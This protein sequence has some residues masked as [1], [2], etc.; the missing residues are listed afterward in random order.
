MKK[1]A[2]QIKLQLPAG[3]AN[4]S[5]PVG[6]STIS[7]DIL[8]NYLS[9]LEADPQNY[10]LRLSVA[11][12]GGQIGM[13]DLAMQQYKQLI[14]R[15]ELLDEVVSTKPKFDRKRPHSPEELRERGLQ[16]LRDAVELLG[17]RLPVVP[18]EV[19]I[20]HFADAQRLIEADIG[21]SV[22]GERADNKLRPTL[23]CHSISNDS[24][25]LRSPGIELVGVGAI[26]LEG[27]RTL[28]RQS[29]RLV[30]SSTGSQESAG[31]T[32]HPDGTCTRDDT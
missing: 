8:D 10:A 2:G 28:D 12:V 22:V 3:K 31:P 13:T 11:R 25:S 7:N 6:P 16:H 18:E 1:V 24:V 30:R 32:A 20:V 15:S 9:L 29:R 21:E 4:P 19:P 14:K 17:I 23:N 27:K 5:P 26:T